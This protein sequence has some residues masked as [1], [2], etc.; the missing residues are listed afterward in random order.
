M[1]RIF[2]LLFL[3]LIVFGVSCYVV[4]NVKTN[5]IKV[6]TPSASP[7]QCVY[8]TQD[9]IL[10]GINK[11]RADV[12]VAPVVLSGELD[13]ISDQ[14]AIVLDGKLDDHIGFDQ[15]VEDK[16]FPFTF[17]HLAENLIGPTCINAVS[18]IV[19]WLNSPGHKENMLNP[20]YDSIGIGIYK[21]LVVTIFGNLR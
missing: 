15:A 18:P 13:I 1:K 6:S 16:K 7:F 21:G 17:Q 9:I 12:G 8:S 14:R 11:A 10:E 3:F 4:R 19:L 2:Y 5:S 20:N